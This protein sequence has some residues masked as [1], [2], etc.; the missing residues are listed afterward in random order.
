[1]AKAMLD[2]FAAMKDYRVFWRIG[3]KLNL[4][5]MNSS[6]FEEDLPANINITTFFPQQELLGEW[7]VRVFGFKTAYDGS[8]S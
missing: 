7:W 6:Q 8:F 2:A 3:R 5:G 1:M 4:A